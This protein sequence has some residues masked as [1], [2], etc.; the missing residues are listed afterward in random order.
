MILAAER[1]SFATEAAGRHAAG[2]FSANPDEVRFVQ[3]SENY[4]YDAGPQFLR[5]TPES[6]RTESQLRGELSFMRW[7]KNAGVTTAL[8]CQSMNAKD[9]EA[10]EYGWITAISR[11]EG[12]PVQAF[13]PMWNEALFRAW[14]RTMAAI[15]EHG[16]AWPDA[17][18]RWHW[19]ADPLAL[20]I[21]T[22]LPAEPMAMFEYNLLRHRLADLPIENYGP[23]HGDFGRPNFHLTE[24]GEVVAFDFDDCGL[25]WHLY[26]LA[27]ALWPLRHQ[28]VEDRARYQ[29]WMFA[30]YQEVRRLP[31]GDFDLFL[32]WRHLCLYANNRSAWTAPDE[33]QSAWLTRAAAAIESP[34]RWS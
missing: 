32:R 5:I 12:A 28:P 4:V 6:H 14:G 24:S 18:L 10:S 30:G 9:V 7:L 26:D 8:P 17:D 29:T 33:P 2:L 11:A 1:E 23:I 20:R 16:L 34:L 21:L 3:A 27:I 25:H 22:V 19:D 15:H 13:G 31:E